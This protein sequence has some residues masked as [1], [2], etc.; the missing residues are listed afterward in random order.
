MMLQDE[1]PLL[2]LDRT[3]DNMDYA[4]IGPVHGRTRVLTPRAIPILPSARLNGTLAMGDFPAA[5]AFSS[6][7][8]LLSLPVIVSTA[9]SGG[10]WDGVRRRRASGSAL[11]A[12]G[13]R[14]PGDPSGQ[15]CTRPPAS[16]GRCTVKRITGS[17][18]L[19]SPCGLRCG[20]PNLA[21]SQAQ[22]ERIRAARLLHIAG[23]PGDKPRAPCGNMRSAWTVSRR[24]HC[25][26]A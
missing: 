13:G 19:P 14:A 16:G 22:L 6:L 12:M 23:Y 15:R 17:L 3:S 10:A 11:D 8:A 1:Q 24:G 7:R 5:A 4:I 18:G 20:H 26:T 25:S 21:P 2:W 9:P